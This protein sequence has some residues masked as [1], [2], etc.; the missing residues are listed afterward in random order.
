M[1]YRELIKQNIGK[2]VAKVKE[3][4]GEKKY[5]FH[6]LGINDKF[7]TGGIDYKGNFQGAMY[8]KVDKRSGRKIENAGF[9]NQSGV[10]S[11]YGFQSHKSVRVDFVNFISDNSRA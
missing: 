1:T 7:F 8:E 10:G 5:P 11:L 4:G 6:K 2:A 9:H 3:N